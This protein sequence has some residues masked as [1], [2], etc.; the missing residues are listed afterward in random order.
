MRDFLVST[1][2]RKGNLRG[3]WHFATQNPQKQTANQWS[4]YGGRLYDTCMSCM[5]L[6]VYYRF[7]PIYDSKATDDKFEIF[8]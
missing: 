2:G 5:T 1:Q 6:E 7:L 4:I 3:S 8:E